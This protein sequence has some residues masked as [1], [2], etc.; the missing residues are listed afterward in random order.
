LDSRTVK[1]FRGSFDALTKMGADYC[2]QDRFKPLK[3]AGKPLWEFK[4]FDYRLFCFRHVLP[5]KR[6]EVVLFNGWVKDKDGR[7]EKEDREIAT[8]KCFY[9]EFL[10]EYPGGNL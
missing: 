6:I 5:E 10:S 2:N 3:D 1:K 9:K 8:A 7:H 4:E